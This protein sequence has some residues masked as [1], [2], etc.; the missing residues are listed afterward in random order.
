MERYGRMGKVGE[1]IAKIGAIFALIGV[2]IID[3]VGIYFVISLLL[4]SV[5]CIIFG[6][7]YAMWIYEKHSDD[8][9][10]DETEPEYYTMYDK[11]GN[12]TLTEKKH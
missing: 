8:D 4:I 11:Y 2:T 10:R 7:G 9:T 1:I 12:E 3:S 6:M 5:G